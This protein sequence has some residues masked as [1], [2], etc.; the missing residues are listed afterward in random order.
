MDHLR[1]EITRLR[2]ENYELRADNN[3]YKS[4]LDILGKQLEE[5]KDIICK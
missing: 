5:I 3:I 2:N 4:L 1:A